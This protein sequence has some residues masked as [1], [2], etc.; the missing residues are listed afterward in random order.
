[1]KTLTKILLAAALGGAAISYAGPSPQYWQ[2]R[3][4]AKP[5]PVKT[6]SALQTRQDSAGLVCNYMVVA[7]TGQGFSKAP[8][9]TVRCTPEVMKN[10]WRCQQACAKASKG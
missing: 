5:R 3:P 4:A 6:Q 8:I 9:M 7:N 2:N 1:M 10:D